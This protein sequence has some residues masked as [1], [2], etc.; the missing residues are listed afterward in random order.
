MSDH[1]SKIAL[2][3]LIYSERAFY[4]SS[5]P[6]TRS[7]LSDTTTDAELVVD[8]GDPAVGPGRQLRCSR[9]LF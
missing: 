6:N 2:E 3:H 9:R 5:V 1:G 7:Y 4:S 8:I